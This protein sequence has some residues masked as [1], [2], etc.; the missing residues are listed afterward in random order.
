MPLSEIVALDEQFHEKLVG[1]SGDEEIHNAL[2]S[3]NVRI[4]PLRYL[5]VDP[6][7]MALG[8][9]Q[10]REICEALRQ[11]DADRI[12]TLLAVHIHRSLED[13]EAAVR[14]LYGRIYAA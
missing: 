7:R 4:R 14:E 2:R 6:D 9:K 5:G 12:G 10:Q 1:F 11:R 8:D 13:V 3:V